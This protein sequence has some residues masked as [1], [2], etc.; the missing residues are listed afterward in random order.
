MMHLHRRPGLDHD[1]RAGAQTASDQVM[2]HRRGRQ[3]HRDGDVIQIGVAVREDED[4]VAREHRLLGLLAESVERRPHAARPLGGR[5]DDVEGAGAE[6]RAGAVLDV[7]DALQ[8]LIGQHRL[9]GLETPVLAGLVDAEQIGP[10]PDHADQRHHQ[11]LADRIDRRIGDLREVLL[12]I[13]REMLGSAGEH[14]DR[15]V[16]AHGADRLLTR[17]DHRGQ[18]ELDVLLGVAEAAANP[19]AW[20]RPG[21]WV[22]RWSAAR[23][24]GSG[25]SSATR[26]RVWPR[27][28]GS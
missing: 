13:G 22:R 24:A 23:R 7:P 3:Q 6:G 28:A 18:Q 14:R 17:E 9:R 25:S 12:E 8:V 21:T 20:R 27:R 2:M 26:H 16:R 4:V 11:L 15:V 5:I 19:T 1:P 10:R